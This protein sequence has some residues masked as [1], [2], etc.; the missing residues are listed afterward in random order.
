MSRHRILSKGRV[1][2]AICIGVISM[3]TAKHSLAV[4]RHE[5]L[6]NSGDGTQ[7]IDSAGTA[8]GTVINTTII[9]AD[10]R[11]ALNGGD[12][13]G[14]LPG[15]TIGINTYSEL[16]IEMWLTVS[17]AN[18]N[19]F[20]AATAFG[21]TLASGNGSNYI[22]MQPTR[23]FG[24]QSS[25]QITSVSGGEE[26]FVGGPQISNGELRHIA[27][28]INS[29]EITYYI[30]GVQQGSTLLSA[31]TTP[32]SLADI[33]T[34]F[35]YIGNSVWT[36]D[37]TLIGSIYEMRIYDDA[38]DATGIETLFNSGCVDDC[39]GDL[40]LEIDRN[41]GAGRII[42]DL[43]DRNMVIY[44]ITSGNGALLT[45]MNGW[46]PIT[47]S[48][49]DPDDN[50]EILVDMRTEL[51]EQDPLGQGNEDGVL[52]TAGSPISLGNIWNKSPY[53]DVQMNITYLDANFIEQTAN[54]PV[55]FI[56]GVD[57]EPFAQGDFDLD[58]DIDVDDFNTFMDHHLEDF[59]TTISAE[60]PIDT[61]AFGDMNGD[62]FN[63]YTDFR[64]FKAA[65]V[66][67]N[68]A[69]AFQALVNGQPVP[70]PKAVLIMLL[71]V[72]GATFF[73]G[74]QLHQRMH[75]A[76]IRCNSFALETIAMSKAFKWLVPFALLAACGG[77]GHAQEVVVAE[78]FDTRVD[79]TA[80]GVEGG[81]TVLTLLDQGGG[82][83]ALQ[84][85]GNSDAGGFFA[86]GFTLPTLEVEPGAGGPNISG[87]VA[88]Y[89]LSFDLTINAINDFTPNLEIWLGDGPRFAGNN[90]NLYTASGLVNGTQS[91]SFSLNENLTT[92]AP[93]GFNNPGTWSP[94]ADDW[95]LQ[96]NTISFGAPAGAAVD[97]TIN[98]F[99]VTIDIA[100][101]LALV[102]DP[103][104]GDTLIR[105]ITT[106]PITFDYYQIQSPDDGALI[107]AD[108][109]EMAGTGWNSL[110]DQQ[111]D[112][113]GA[114]IDENWAEVT[115]VNSANQ[116]VEQFLLGATTLAGGQEIYLG[117][118]IDPNLLG[119]TGG[120]P[121]SL[122]FGGEAYPALALGS[123]IFENVEPPV[124]LGGDFNGDGIVNLADYTVW[125]NNLGAPESVLPEGSGNGSGTVDTG[126]YDLWKLN[127]GTSSGAAALSA[128]NAA[129]VPEPT[130]WILTGLGGL[131]FGFTR[132]RSG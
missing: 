66:D 73:R 126:D 30:D 93:N 71:G 119:D 22:M 97:Y 37:P 57:G 95:W 132:R 116:L 32:A 45:N 82:D 24:D 5:Y 114:G 6:F 121:L 88:D 91:I 18:T 8:D 83:Q 23:G 74:L 52:L 49:L 103:V 48:G 7:I 118:P 56:N 77:I 64:L 80:F 101:S 10:S 98:N 130:T 124:G 2:G 84:F 109:D 39:G 100:E 110:A 41:T 115:F 1:V 89:Q 122:S 50:W 76:P 33:S 47:D 63:D 65:Y 9:P 21:T 60:L 92:T 55:R 68:G 17:P 38:K 70:E 34:D 25:A 106:E 105:N 28:T 19:I 94:T 12:Q 104:D 90:A 113:V 85:T 86:A 72:F 4:L 125:R 44:S 35:A 129:S 111:R 108:Y 3:L 31:P 43:S 11:L 13:Y 46:D 99:Q 69:A 127:F 75:P 42:N 102:V 131:L 26:A 87:N 79:T 123:V 117:A 59:A 16:T 78:S 54:L 36:F 112:S 81:T 20:T 107:T 96:V 58:G 40:F 67:A 51:S 27:T 15:S 14:D 128:V 53:E 29:T 120:N 61:F 62:L